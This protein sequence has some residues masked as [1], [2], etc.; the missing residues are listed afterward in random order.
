[1]KLSIL[2]CWG[3]GTVGETTSFLL[4]MAG[5]TVLID[6]GLS[7]ARQMHSINRVLPE[8][9]Y[10]F[11]SHV[12]ADHLQGLPY[13]IFARGVQERT[14]GR[15]VDPL[16]IVSH[17]EGISA[18]QQICKLLYPERPLQAEWIEIRNGDSLQINAD[19]KVHVLAVDHTVTCFAYRFDG[20]N[21]SL[22]FSADTLPSEALINFAKGSTVM[23]QE[24]FGTV[25]D[26]GEVH[27]N[28]KHSL[29]IH[30]GEVAEKANI[31]NLLL[32][33]MHTRYSQASKRSELIE[34]VSKHY[35]GN[36]IFPQDLQVLSF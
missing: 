31:A 8:V 17:S 10:V 34:E 25:P 35:K 36:I 1:M 9:S 22:T 14:Y 12:H 13:A 5:T 28:L 16:K 15:K 29:G 23:I 11:I 2:G 32:Y 24:A 18:A 20:P 21:E 26:F 19:L 4:D 30:A 7:P 33:H 3:V 6:A 27:K